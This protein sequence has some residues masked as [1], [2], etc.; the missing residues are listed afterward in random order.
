MVFKDNVSHLID[1]TDGKI[2]ITSH[3]SGRKHA[4]ELSFYE[5]DQIEFITAYSHGEKD[6]TEK[7]WYKD[8]NI[9]HE[10]DY[11]YGKEWG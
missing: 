9:K 5:N 8:G 4:Y 10:C 3:L 2:K 7:S 11:R 1:K 6:G